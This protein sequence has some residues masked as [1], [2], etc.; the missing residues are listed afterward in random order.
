[1]F[2]KWSKWMVF[3]YITFSTLWLN[4]VGSVGISWESYV[5]FPVVLRLPDLIQ[6]KHG[7]PRVVPYINAATHIAIALHITCLIV[8]VHIHIFFTYSLLLFINLLYF[9]ERYFD[10][11]ITLIMRHH[12][13]QNTLKRMNKSKTWVH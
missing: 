11:Q 2:Y 3:G 9:T 7:C 1:M 5:P 12:R 6:Y 10:Y 13:I 8:P 4:F